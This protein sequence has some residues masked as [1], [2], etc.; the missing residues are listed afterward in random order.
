[1]LDRDF[2]LTPLKPQGRDQLLQ[3]D[4]EVTVQS[5]EPAQGSAGGDKRLLELLLLL[6]HHGLV[7]GKSTA[8]NNAKKIV[9]VAVVLMTRHSLFRQKSVLRARI[10]LQSNNSR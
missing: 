1:M 6:F 7:L 5:L 4:Q 3:A 10:T 9:F 2:V 8:R